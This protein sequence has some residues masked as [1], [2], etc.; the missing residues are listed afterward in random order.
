MELDGQTVLGIR[1]PCLP[2]GTAFFPFDTAYPDPKGGACR[3]DSGRAVTG[4]SNT[5]Q[6]TFYPNG[7]PYDP[8]MLTLDHTQWEIPDQPIAVAI[9]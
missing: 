3:D 1:M 4:Q 9:Q 8:V 5:F 2:D 6:N 7:F